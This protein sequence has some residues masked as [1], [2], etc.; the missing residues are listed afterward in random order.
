M[1]MLDFV[2]IFA[3]FLLVLTLGLISSKKVKTIEDYATGGRFYSAFFIFATLSSSFIGGGFTTGL[4]SKVFSCG[5][6]Y[7]VA[8]WGFSL[9]EILIAQ[10]IAPCM[11]RYRDAISVGDI[12]ARSYGVGAQLLTGLS[13]VLLCAGIAAAQFSAFGHMLQLLLGVP[14]IYG[15]CLGALLVVL[16]SSLGG[17]KAVVANDTLH[18]CVL[19]IALPLVFL[20]GLYKIGGP[21]ILFEEIGLQV[22]INPIS[23]KEL[24]ALFI[25]FFLGETLVPPYVQR[26][27]IGKDSHQT[28]KG[29]IWSGLL[30]IPFFLMIGLIGLIAFKLDSAVEPNTA[31]VFVLQE[32][33]P[34]GLRGFAMA[35]MIAVIMSSAD[36]FLNAAGIAASWDIIDVLYKPK[37]G[38]LRISRVATLGVGVLSAYFALTSIGVLDLLLYAYSFWTPVILVPLMAAILGYSSSIEGFWVSSLAGIGVAFSYSWLYP[39]S[40]NATLLGV[41]V[42]SFCFLFFSKMKER[43]SF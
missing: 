11:S 15:V 19:I 29:T 12:M 23:Y 39:D 8:L 26:L 16:Y 14:Y 22:P 3:Y 1:A 28:Q 37:K 35:G 9:K 7:V 42:N 24:I 33:M 17:M 25:S 13:S 20:F 31:L 5:L 36:S 30:S 18:F 10:Y 4:A 27:L 21:V 6:L 38:L 40:I 2:V 32:T 43:F 34:I 41:A